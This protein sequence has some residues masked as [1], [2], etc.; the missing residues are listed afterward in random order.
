MKIVIFDTETTGLAP[1]ETSLYQTNSWPHVVQF[2]FIIFNS[3]TNKIE[4]N[5]DYIIKIPKEIS[6]SK[7]STK[8][9]GIT[10][11]RCNKQGYY[12]KD[13]LEIFKIALDKCHFLVAHNINFDKKMLMVESIRNDVNLNFNRNGLNLYCT[14]RNGIELCDIEVKNKEGE[15]Y[16]KFPTLLELHY[17]LFHVIPNNLHNSMIDIL[18]CLRCFYKMIYDDDLCKKNKNFNSLVTNMT[19]V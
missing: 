12:M 5:H 11:Q 2:S 9:H 6:I 13:V 17:K 16:K 7:E 15:I 8:V 19:G 18:I 4:M 3:V 14:M 10:K 1:K